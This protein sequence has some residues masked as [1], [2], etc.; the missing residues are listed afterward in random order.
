MYTYAYASIRL[1]DTYCVCCA[2]QKSVFTA[3]IEQGTS[4][5]S[6]YEIAADS[7]TSAS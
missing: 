6:S 1:V 3:S 7:I 2:G 5:S 4:I